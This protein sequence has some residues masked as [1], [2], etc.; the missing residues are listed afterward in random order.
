M[1]QPE[2]FLRFEDVRTLSMEQFSARLKTMEKK[3]VGSLNVG[4]LCAMTEYPNGL[5]FFF[6]EVD[7]LQYVGKSSSRSFIER[8][9]SHFDPRHDAWF[10][11]LPKKLMLHAGFSE[12]LAAHSRGLELR[13]VMLGIKVRGTINTLE[14]HL[15]SYLQP[16][17]NAA[18]PG[19]VSADTL[20]AAS[21]AQ[22]LAQA[23][24]QR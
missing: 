22:P 7:L 4:E 16:A 14:T 3:E 11:T 5:Y 18:R 23:E 2:F 9:P 17:L 24:R 10:N 21:E 1:K 19:R 13:V 8:V 6:D 12:Y 20:L 15:R